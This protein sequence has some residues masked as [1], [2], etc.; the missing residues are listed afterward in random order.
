MS[1]FSYAAD[2]MN[3]WL[4]HGLVFDIPRFEEQR[5]LGRPPPMP[6]DIRAPR[7]WQNLQGPLPELRAASLFCHGH[8]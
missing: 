2:A 5:N 4:F 3:V 7:A 8:D 1:N 6:F